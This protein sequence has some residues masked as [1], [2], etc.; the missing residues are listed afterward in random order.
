[1]VK[2]LSNLCHVKRGQTAI[3]STHTEAGKFVSTMKKVKDRN[4]PDCEIATFL[5]EYKIP[6]LNESTHTHTHTHIQNQ[7]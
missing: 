6:S 7:T 4:N 2:V 3:H 5:E 1:M